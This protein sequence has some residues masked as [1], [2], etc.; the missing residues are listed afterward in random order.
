[1]GSPTFIIVTTPAGNKNLEGWTNTIGGN[2]VITEAITLVDSAG[3]EK[4][5]Q[6]PMAASIPVA[7]ASDQSPVP[8]AADAVLD[9]NNSSTTPLAGNATFTGAATDLTHYTSFS[10]MMYADQNSGGSGFQVQFSEDAVNWD[11]VH[12]VAFTAGGEPIYGAWNR[13]A[14]YFRIVYT[15]GATPQGAFRLQ[16]MLQRITQQ[17]DMH[18]ISDLPTDSHVGVITQSVIA[19]HTTAGGGSYVTVKVNPSG[20]LTVD[21]SNSSSVGVTNAGLTNLDVA[22]STRLKPADTLAGVTTVGAVT[23]ITNPVAVTNSNL[24]VALSTRLKPADTLTKVATVDTITNAVT[25]IQ[26]VGTNLHVVVDS[27]SITLAIN[28]ADQETPAGSTPGTAF[29][30]GHTP[31]PSTSLILVLRK[32]VLKNGVDYTL[33]GAS[34]TMIG[35]NTVNTGDVFLAWYR[36]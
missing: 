8:A 25:A 4:I 9:P 28:F 17:V 20:A 33:A 15:N 31:N 2:A 18:F 29:T 36:Y 12:T 24:D 13:L 16:T 22:L 5:A 11:L 14:R 6:Q 23:S 7:I 26:S 30:L 21:A 1:M 3:N 34:L 10:F 19:G 27:G 32:L 35:G